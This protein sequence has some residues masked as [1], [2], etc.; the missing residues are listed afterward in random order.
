MLPSLKYQFVMACFPMKTNCIKTISEQCI[1]SLRIKL[2]FI[3]AENTLSKKLPVILSAFLLIISSTASSTHNVTHFIYF[4]RSLNISK[5][6]C[7]AKAF[8]FLSLPEILSSAC[9]FG[10][11]FSTSVLIWRGEK[12]S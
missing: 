11:F 8:L 3:I 2:F 12:H 6:F 7:D 9:F 1:Y 4:K 10:I 5:F